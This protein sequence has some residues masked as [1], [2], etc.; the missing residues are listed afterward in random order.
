MAFLP[1]TCPLDPIL[2]IRFQNVYPPRTRSL[3]DTPWSVPATIYQVLG[4]VNDD[5]DTVFE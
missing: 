1:F 2:S 3:P 4:R 5:P